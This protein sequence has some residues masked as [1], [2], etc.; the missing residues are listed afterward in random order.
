VNLYLAEIGKYPLLS[1]ADE[2]RLAGLIERGRWAQDELGRD[3]ELPE[4]RARQLRK[5][6]ADADE[7]TRAFV[8]SNLRLVVS[9]ARRYER[10]GLPLLDIIQEGNIG[11]MRAVARFDHRRQLRFSTYAVWP[12]RQA[13]T[14]AIANTARLVRLP[15]R[16]G[17]LVAGVR[18]GQAALEAEYG[19]RPT[20][21]QLAHWLGIP[22]ERVTEALLVDEEPVSLAAPLVARG[23]ERTSA[24]EDGRAVSPL[25]HAVLSIELEKMSL[26][27]AALDEVEYE[28]LRLRFGLDD[29]QPATL[30]EVGRRLELSGAAART[31]QQRAM[32][33]LRRSITAL[34]RVG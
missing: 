6:V 2:L 28:V 3:P 8:A 9:I 17:E 15:V 31:V 18:R 30:T 34:E 33:K 20:V 11:L 13:I 25:E 1:S 5:V 19:R 24:I 12:I 27:M 23:A 22:S 26:A 7:A 21:D 14:R 16:T 29:D 10:P 32:R 4:L